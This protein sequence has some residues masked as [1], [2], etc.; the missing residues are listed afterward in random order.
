[1]REMKM[2]EEGKGSQKRQGRGT[3]KTVTRGETEMPKV[4]RMKLQK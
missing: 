1:M 3:T 4:D 2:V